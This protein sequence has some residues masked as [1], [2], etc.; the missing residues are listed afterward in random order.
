MYSRG[1][2]SAGAIL[3]ESEGC[4]EGGMRDSRD[5]EVCASEMSELCADG[6]NEAAALR[7]RSGVEPKLV[8][9]KCVACGKGVMCCR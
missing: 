1:S 4:W 3:R 7:A 5:R 6:D 9:S 2:A 8:P